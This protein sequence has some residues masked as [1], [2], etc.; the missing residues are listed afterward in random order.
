MAWNDMD[1]LGIT[2]IMD[3]NHVN[4]HLII[5]SC[6]FHLVHFVTYE[7]GTNRIECEDYAWHGV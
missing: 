5:G 6:I 2:L 1:N 7:N 3:L 4:T